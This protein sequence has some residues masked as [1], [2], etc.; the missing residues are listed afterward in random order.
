MET[1]NPR[2]I[3]LVAARYPQ[4]QGLRTMV[5]ALW[6]LFFAALLYVA[7]DEWHAAVFG[8]LFAV[9][10]WYRFRRMPRRLDDYYAQRFGRTGDFLFPEN[11]GLWFG[12][13][14]NFNEPLRDL[15][16][17]PD[18]LRVG[19]LMVGLCTYPLVIVVRDAPYRLYWLAVV[20]AGFAAAIQIPWVPIG[21]GRYLWVRESHLAIGLALLAAGA[22]DHLL[23]AH[24]LRG[25]SPVPAEQEHSDPGSSA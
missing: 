2:L 22:L 23:L 19:V 14:I 18:Y 1:P 8:A 10:L 13:M 5:D 11:L 9:Y 7:K 17:A 12:M 24:T 15:F 3:R 6:P 16:R 4:M 21:E 20:F 25:G